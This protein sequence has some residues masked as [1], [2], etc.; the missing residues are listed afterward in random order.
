MAILADRVVLQDE[1]GFVSE[2]AMTAGTVVVFKT[3]QG[4]GIGVGQGVNDSAPIGVAGPGTPT[5]GN[6]KLA[7]VLLTDVISLDQTKYK[8]NPHKTEQMIGEPMY[9]MRKGEIWTN[10]ITGTPSAGD[11]AYLSTSGTVTNSQVSGAP[12][13]GQFKT[14]KDDNGYA[15]LF[16]DIV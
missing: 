9:L 4:T 14:S 10:S 8:R 5:S 3:S 6:S 13:V 7:G 11:A 15:K 1:I 2:A 16:V 12:K